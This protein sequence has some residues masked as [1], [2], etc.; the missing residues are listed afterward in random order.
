MTSSSV[1]MTWNDNS[2][3]ETGFEVEISATGNASDFSLSAT[4]A[5]DATSHT[6]SG[7]TSNTTY[8]FRIRAVNATGPSSY[9]ST[10]V[11]TT[12]FS[13]GRTAIW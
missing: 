9:T 1:T 13:P 7:L 5:A 8:H 3:N 12:D 11:V 4:T 10:L 2:G 6:V